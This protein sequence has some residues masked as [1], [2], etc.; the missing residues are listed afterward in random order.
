MVS[1][2]IVKSVTGVALC[3]PPSMSFM[4]VSNFRSGEF[5]FD[6]CATI[7]GTVE[8]LV[9]SS[10]G[11]CVVC[12]VVSSTVIVIASGVVDDCS[13]V[14]LL[15]ANEMLVDICEAR[16]LLACNIA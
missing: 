11:E 15:L 2:S 3:S 10:D 4:L 6:R 16:D 12:I 5:L 1:P 9:E 14:L 8:L 7:D 13:P